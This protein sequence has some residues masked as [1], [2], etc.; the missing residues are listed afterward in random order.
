MKSEAPA[1][2]AGCGRAT[3]R[4]RRSR[5]PIARSRFVFPSLL[6]ARGIEADPKSAHGVRKVSVSERQ[7]G[8][9]A[10]KEGAGGSVGAGLS[11][12]YSP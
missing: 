6:R 9:P 12:R 11:L 4:E 3:G 8:R 2:V 10:L 1:V 7:R 5:I